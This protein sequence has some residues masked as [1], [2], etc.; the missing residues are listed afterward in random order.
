MDESNWWLYL[1]GAVAA[2]VFIP[3]RTVFKWIAVA[4][5]AG[6]AF[7]FFTDGGQ[8]PLHRLIG[9][10]FFSIAAIWVARSEYRDDDSAPP[11][12]NKGNQSAEPPPRKCSHCGGTGKISCF[13]TDKRGKADIFGGA[14]LECN[15]MKLKLC[16]MC[17]GSGKL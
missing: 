11:R 5:C 10:V 7:T 13:C 12:E 3:W 2:Y 16:Y 4:V 8:Q 6:L 15:D 17:Y 9:G 1:M 14:C